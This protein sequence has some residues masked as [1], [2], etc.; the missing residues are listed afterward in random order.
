MRNDAACKR[1][2]DAGR[3]DRGRHELRSG[4]YK[5]TESRNGLCE[6]HQTLIDI[7]TMICRPKKPLATRP[8]SANKEGAATWI[9]GVPE[10]IARNLGYTILPAVEALAGDGLTRSQVNALSR[11]A[12]CCAADLVQNCDTIRKLLRTGGIE[13]EYGRMRNGDSLVEPLV[14]QAHSLVEHL[15]SAVDLLQRDSQ[16]A[17]TPPQGT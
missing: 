7:M 3:R 4:M 9:K 17:A 6:L 13:L 15:I 1:A 10:S 16:L 2:F 12:R 5:L 14:Q 11:Y 8:P